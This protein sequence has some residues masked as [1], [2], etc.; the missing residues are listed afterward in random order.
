MRHS[1]RCVASVI[2]AAFILAPSAGLA[3]AGGGAQP[4]TTTYVA[5]NCWTG[6]SDFTFRATGRDGRIEHAAGV[7]TWDVHFYSRE[8]GWFWAG[9]ESNPS[10]D[11]LNT[12]NGIEVFRGK[13]V[14]T[15]PLVGDFEGSFTL[16]EGP[17]RYFGRG[18]GR[19]TDGSGALW[20]GTLGTVDPAPYL[21]LPECATGS[22]SLDVVELTYP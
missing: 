14:F 3:A 6:G 21:P 9:T 18:V 15:S 11:V 1:L 4:M 13:F 7:I 8:T 16:Q 22:E 5:V 10:W 17:S 20:K 2:L 12:G 19:S